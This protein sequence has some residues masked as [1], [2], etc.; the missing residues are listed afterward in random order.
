M[1]TT[2]NVKRHSDGHDC[3]GY[4][5]HGTQTE[6]NVSRDR[7][8]E[9]LG[10]ALMTHGNATAVESSEDPDIRFFVFQNNHEEGWSRTE[11]TIKEIW[12]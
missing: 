4:I 10:A 1:N 11:I 7:V 12:S 2:F 3:D 9:I 8:N 5:T 6:M